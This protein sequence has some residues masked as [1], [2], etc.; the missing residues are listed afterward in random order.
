[1]IVFMGVLLYKLVFHLEKQDKS[2][3]HRQNKEEEV[4]GLIVRGSDHRQ[5]DDGD[6]SDVIYPSRGVELLDRNDRSHGLRSK[7]SSTTEA[8]L[9]V[10]RCT[11]SS[12]DDFDDEIGLQA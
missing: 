5:I 10:S 7:L 6:S 1:M 12:D 9:R 11:S 2:E 3:H 4:S 8:T